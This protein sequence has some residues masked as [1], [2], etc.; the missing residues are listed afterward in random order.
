MRRVRGVG[1]GVWGTAL[2]VALAA[3][4]R[5]VTV[6]VNEGAKRLVVEARIERVQGNVTG[7]QVIRL[8]ETNAYFD[9][10]APPPATGAAVQVTDDQGTIVSFTES[11]AG[12]YRTN[13]LV[14][15]VGRTYTLS[16]IFQGQQYQAT[17]QLLSVAP[18]DTLY[19]APP[20]QDFGPMGLRATI[21]FRE[22]GG[23]ENW[24]LWEQFVNGTRV[25]GPDSLFRLPVVFSDLGIDGREQ[26]NFQPFSGMPVVPGEQ[27]LVRQVALSEKVYHY[28]LALGEQTTNDGSPFAVPAASVRGNVRNL[29]N[30][31]RPALGYF[32]AAEVAEARARP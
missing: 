8:S 18:I 9:S 31:S 30:P 5:V 21:D 20:T 26:V 19:F 3:C 15:V 22:P 2:A 4:E 11:P 24:Y 10:S 1:F 32:I 14:G 23:V 17:E 25:L 12:V 28:F 27:V 13:A 7:A 6:Q 16:I 29:S